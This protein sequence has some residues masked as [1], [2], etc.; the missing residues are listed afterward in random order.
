MEIKAP[1]P[2]RNPSVS[3]QTTLRDEDIVR[4]VSK[5][6]EL[7]GCYNS[8][9]ICEKHYQAFIDDSK[10]EEWNPFL[11]SQPFELSP[12]KECYVCVPRINKLY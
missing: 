11:V 6:K 9:K 7:D 1:T 5:L 4:A 10:K 12:E 3:T 8:F 2:E